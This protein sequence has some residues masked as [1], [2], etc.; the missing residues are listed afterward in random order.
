MIH[1]K[2]KIWFAI[3]LEVEDYSGDAFDLCS[4]VPTDTCLRNLSK[5][6][7]VVKQQPNLLTHLVEVHASGPD[8]DKPLFEPDP[9]LAFRYQLFSIGSL[10]QQRSNIQTLEPDKYHL[11]LSNNADNKVGSNLY[12]H[13]SGQAAGNSDRVFKA[14]FS[15]VPSG[16]LAVAD[17][18][19]NNLV[20]ADYRLQASNGKCR[21]PVYVIRLARHP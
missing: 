18:F 6:R 3:R 7:M 20:S 12:M 13:K 21:E 14:M 2:F 17:V 5:T 1:I 19:Q 9:L 10:L 8:E 15:E 11:Y 16:A 4:L